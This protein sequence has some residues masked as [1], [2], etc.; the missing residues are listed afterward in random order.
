M[1]RLDI[2]ELSKRCFQYQSSV[3]IYGKEFTIEQKTKCSTVN[4]W[5]RRDAK[6]GLG[7]EELF[8]ANSNN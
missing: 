2:S 4:A 8:A 6:D 1:P 7:C 5:G 3:P